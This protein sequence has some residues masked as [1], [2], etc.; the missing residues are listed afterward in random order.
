[1]EKS[2]TELLIGA[3]L[4][5]FVTQRKEKSIHAGNRMI[6]VH[7]KND[8]ILYLPNGASVKVSVDDSGI[9]T[10]VEE[11]ENLHAIVRPLTFHQKL[12]GI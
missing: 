7:E 3:A 10:Q 2:F 1:M 8:R 6:K 5:K 9:V 11:E 12:R 4:D